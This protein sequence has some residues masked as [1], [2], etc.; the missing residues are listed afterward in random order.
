MSTLKGEPVDRPAVSFYEINGLDESPD[1]S[2]PFN[3]FSH[4]SWK[5]LVTLARDKTDR[6][7]M[8]QVNKKS[9]L[10]GVMSL[11]EYYEN[12][13]LFTINT[14]RVGSQILTSR[15]RRDPDVF[16]IWQTEHLLKNV[17]D[18]R[19]FLELPSF[20]MLRELD[21]DRIHETEKSLGD[22]GIV[23]LDLGDPL[24]NAA[25]LFDMGT[26]TMIAMTEPALFHKLL[27]K[28]AEPIYKYVRLVS[29]HFPGRLW[30][31]YGPEYASVPYLPPKYFDEYVVKYDSPIVNMIHKSGGFAR[32][33][34][35]G[36]LRDILDKIVST[37]CMAID[38]IEPPPHGDVTLEYVRKKYGSQ[39]VL[40]GNLEITDIENLP[41]AQFEE[42]VKR[43]IEE[44]MSGN[45][46]GF[47]LMQSASPYGRIVSENTI[48]NYESI[49]KIIECL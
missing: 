17:D 14:I 1:H 40:F 38:P 43:S 24:C 23:M 30:R 29:Q 25:S 47:V 41:N 22:T 31:I 4:P 19:A 13:S 36:N 39:L 3:V 10:S 21:F 34:S 45:G 42:K 49:I 9:A 27:E 32:V 37:G 18:L 2:D 7:V 8:R 5:P 11:K 6:I 33:H 28:F 44:G 46:R 15:S 48:K 26:F 20:D 16:T 35:H 12:G